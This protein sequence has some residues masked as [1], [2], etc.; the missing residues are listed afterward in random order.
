[1][2]AKE[3]FCLLLW[4]YQGGQINAKGLPVR[5]PG[6]RASGNCDEPSDCYRCPLMQQEIA[7]HP[8]GMANWVCPSCI[9]EVAKLA[10]HRGVRFYF[11]SHYTEGQ[12]QYKGCTREPRVEYRDINPALEDEE[13]PKPWDEGDKIEYPARYSRLLQLV[14]GDINS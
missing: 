7:R 10:R 8:P 12:C 9:R 5:T 2:G 11:T 6:S 3:A 13:H 1:M 4:G 14:I